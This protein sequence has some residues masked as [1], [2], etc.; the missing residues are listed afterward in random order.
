MHHSY[1]DGVSFCCALLPT[2][3]KFDFIRG[4]KDQM[5][6]C[7]DAGAHTKQNIKLSVARSQSN[8]SSDS[9]HGASSDGGQQSEE[10]HCDSAGS[11][12]PPTPRTNSIIT[13]LDDFV[14]V[15]LEKAVAN[16]QAI[17]IEGGSDYPG[18][19]PSLMES[20]VDSKW[21]D[22]FEMQAKWYEVV[23][24]WIIG[25]LTMPLTIFR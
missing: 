5:N 10:S 19:T 16:Q 9:G 2:V 8:Q 15:D 24:L 21:R 4:D 14:T 23:M 7:R 22:I 11:T 12:P 6:G 18:A 17:S 25:I 1:G 3:F 13:N 20:K